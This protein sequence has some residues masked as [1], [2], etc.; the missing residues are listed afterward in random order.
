AE[1]LELAKSR[2]LAAVSHE[3]RTPLNAIIGFSDMLLHEMFGGFSDPRQKEYVGLVSESGHHLLAVV[4]SILDV[5]RIEAGTYSTCPE[6]FRFSDAI[7]TCHS[8]L[9]QQAAG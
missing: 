6:P 7:D 2:F 3:L 1:E 8:M 9:S 5:S 4:N